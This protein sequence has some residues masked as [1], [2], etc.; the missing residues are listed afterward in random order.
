MEDAT[1]E[2]LAASPVRS[3][4]FSSSAGPW[5][6]VDPHCR[7]RGELIQEWLNDCASLPGS[8]GGPIFQHLK[9]DGRDVI[10][11]VGMQTS[12]WHSR[13]PR[14]YHTIYANR[15]TKIGYLAQQIKPFLS[16]SPR[17]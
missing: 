3:A 13:E 15:A 5:P 2:E 17:S 9:V 6:I 12:A 4:G 10:R 16:T 8:S 14:P 1:R 7:V 11:L